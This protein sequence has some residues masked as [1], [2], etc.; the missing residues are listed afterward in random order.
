MKRC[1]LYL[2]LLLP[3]FLFADVKDRLLKVLASN[4]AVIIKNFLDTI[5]SSQMYDIS[6]YWYNEREV[7][8]GFTETTFLI[9]ERLAIGH[10]NF[11]SVAFIF[12]GNKEKLGYYCFGKLNINA[13]GTDWKRH[14]DTIVCYRNSGLLNEFNSKFENDFGVKVDNNELFEDTIVFGQK[15]SYSYIDPYWKSYMDSLVIGKDRQG[16]MKLV[17]SSNG[18]KQLYGVW[19]FSILE[20][21]GKRKGIILTELETMR[22]QNVLKKKGYIHSCI[23]FFFL[24]ETFEDTAKRHKIKFK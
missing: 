24:I 10:F 18:E 13:I 7:V 17:Q 21:K 19:G 15:C 12:K 4:D 3:T 20:K 23:G 6:G 14:F 22:I 8:S 9:K 1:L 2:L 16:L 5:P 11:Y